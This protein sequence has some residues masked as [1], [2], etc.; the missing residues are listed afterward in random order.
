MARGN[1]LASFVAGFGTSYFNAEEKKKDRERQ[2]RLDKQAA[3]EHDI[4]M[5]QLQRQEKDADKV[6]ALNDEIAAIPRQT[7]GVKRDMT[8]DDVRGMMGG[9]ADPNAENHVSD[10]AAQH[11]IKNN[12][13]PQQVASNAASI[14]Q[15]G[16][17]NNL[18]G[19]KPVQGEDGVQLADP[20]TAKRRPAWK[21]MEEAANKRVGSGVP[22]QEQLGYQALA[23]AQ[24]MKS[25]EARDGAMKAFRQGGLDGVMKFM[26]EWDN[27]DYPVTNIRMDAGEGGY[28]PSG[29]KGTVKFLGDING[30]SVTLKEYDLSKMPEGRTLEDAVMDDV[31]ML[32]D[33]KAMFDMRRE[34]LKL[35]R[36]DIKDGRQQS[37]VDREHEFKVNEAE[38]QG[39]RWEKSH[40]AD[41]AQRRFDNYMKSKNFD[42][43]QKYRSDSLALDRDKLDASNGPNSE[44][45]RDQYRQDY[46]AALAAFDKSFRRDALG[47][48]VGNELDSKLYSEA[49]DV[50]GLEILAGRPVA[51]AQSVGRAVYDEAK[52]GGVSASAAYAAL[53]K[54]EQGGNGRKPVP[55]AAGGTGA[56]AVDGF[57]NQ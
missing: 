42:A 28:D 9:S 50:I 33:P 4:R 18:G 5:R 2:E 38:K 46:N 11:Y 22:Q 57:F 26:S 29:R 36:D 40:D 20:S 45:A 35:R 17:G 10:E 24:T 21:I 49:A 25:Q 37:N 30:K 41:Q 15:Q 1:G 14:A 31:Q 6:D 51:Q 44:K 43:D 13:G 27:D 3:D 48:M 12:I 56:A 34:Q 16:I 32:T 19:M 47:N 8:P 39:E 23:Y 52:K 7:D 53:K 55:A 54:R